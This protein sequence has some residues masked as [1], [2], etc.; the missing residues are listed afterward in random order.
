MIGGDPFLKIR[1][2]RCLIG[3]SDLFWDR[4]LRARAREVFSRR[5]YASAQELRLHSAEEF[6]PS[7]YKHELN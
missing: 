6:L 3:Y 2:F 5:S 1:F 4:L 7:Q